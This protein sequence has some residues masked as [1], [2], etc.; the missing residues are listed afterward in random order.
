MYQNENLLLFLSVYFYVFRLLRWYPLE[1]DSKLEVVE[2]KV[3]TSQNF[4]NYESTMK[5]KTSLI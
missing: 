1:N 3:P 4:F 5:D 2:Q